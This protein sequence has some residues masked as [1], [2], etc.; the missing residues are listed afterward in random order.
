MKNTTSGKEKPRD[1]S[2]LADPHPN[3]NSE[4]EADQM[5]A[6][7]AKAI[8]HPTRVRI[9]RMLAKRDARVCSQI[10]DEFPVAQS[11][12]S[13]CLRILKESG[14]INSRADGPRIQYCINRA[15]LEEL[16]ELVRAL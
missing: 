11:T 14:L 9:L 16:K 8:F 4:E 6:V 5:L 7:M 3:T 2:S 15:A 12:V 1:G 10:V 13:E